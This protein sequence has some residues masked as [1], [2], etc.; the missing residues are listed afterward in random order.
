MLAGASVNYKGIFALSGQHALVIG[1]GGGIGLAICQGFADVGAHIA[2]LDISDEIA[3]VA[4][5]AARERGDLEAFPVTCDIRYPE[6]IQTAV[7]KVLDR[8]GKID[9]LVNPAGNGILKPAMDFT[10][11]DW[12]E[13]MHVYLRSTFLFAQAVGRNM[14]SRC[15]G[16]IINISS[17]ASIVALG[18]G[19]AAYSAAKAGVNAL[20][21]ELAL[22]WAKKGVRVNAIAPCQIDTPQLRRLLQDPQFDQEK[23][24]NVWLDAIPMGRIGKPDDIVGPCIFLASEAS[25]LITGHVLLVDGGYTVK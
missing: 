7:A 22:E 23:L 20:T 14:V 2:C 25:K 19:T 6:K 24:M 12:E 9:I 8:F 15:S 4:T 18:R 1:A 16:S 3:I 13:M 17:V 21:R 11:E 5:Q 10:L